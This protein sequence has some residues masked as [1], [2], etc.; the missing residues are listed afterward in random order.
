MSVRGCVFVC[1]CGCT[2]VDDCL[3]MCMGFKVCVGLQVC[4]ALRVLVGLQM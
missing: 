4:V 2:F 1:V 3:W